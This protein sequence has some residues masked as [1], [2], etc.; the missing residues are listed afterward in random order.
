MTYLSVI[1]LLAA[2]S[3]KDIPVTPDDSY[4]IIC[5]TLGRYPA[6]NYFCAWDSSESDVYA[7][8]DAWFKK[9]ARWVLDEMDAT[10]G[11]MLY[12]LREN[13]SDACN[14]PLNQLGSSF[15][16]IRNE[17]TYTTQAT[18]PDGDRLRYGWDWNGDLEVDEW[19][20]YFDSGREASIAHAWNET[21][22]HTIQV[23]AQDEF[24]GETNWSE[25]M[26]VVMPKAFDR[27]LLSLLAHLTHW[28]MRMLPPVQ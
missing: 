6:D 7:D 16:L 15:G 27:P 12:Q 1:L 9:H 19:T 10:N 17:Y 13:E 28:C 21:G 8:G 4:Y 3:L 20:P 14:P 22:I 11:F 18:D 24:G 23:K 5:T 25:P 2:D 26:S